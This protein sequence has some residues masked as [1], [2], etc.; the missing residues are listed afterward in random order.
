VATSDELSLQGNLLHVLASR[1]VLT[2][3]TIGGTITGREL[4][5]TVT[6]DG[7]RALVQMVHGDPNSGDS[8]FLVDPTTG[9][10]V[11]V[12]AESHGDFDHLPWPSGFIDHDRTAV[13]VRDAPRGAPD[14]R[15][16]VFADA[17]T[18]VAQG[19]PQP[20]PGSI[21]GDWASQDRLR[22]TP[23]GRTLT[24]VVDGV[25]RIW[26]RTPQGWRGPQRI[27]LPRYRLATLLWFAEGTR[28][29]A[30][31]RYAAF[32]VSYTGRFTT[33]PPRVGYMLDL[34]NGRFVQ[35]GIPVPADI[36]FSPDGK[37]I[38]TAS[39][40]GVVEI[41]P[42]GSGG[43]KP[44]SIP[45][46]GPRTLA[47]S[48]DGHRLAIGY[49]DGSAVVYT[50]D[51]LRRVLS[52]PPSG[53]QLVS[54]ALPNA[55]PR[56]LALDFESRLTTYSLTGASAQRL[57]DWAPGARV[58][59]TV[60]TTSPVVR[61]A[62]GP[63]DVG[64][65]VVAAG[66]LNGR[67]SLYAG[68]ALQHL[69]DL[70]LGP[71]PKDPSVDPA[72]HRKVTALA[73]TPDGE[74]VIAAD[75][76]GH[77]RMWSTE[78]GR[79]L[80]SRDDVPA[81]YLAVSPDG[82]YLATSEFTQDRRAPEDAID[83]D[84]LAVSST[85]RVWDL[86]QPG[87]VVFSD[88][89]DDFTDEFGHTPKPL[90]LSFSPDSSLLAAGTG[91]AYSS[92]DLLLVYDPHTGRRVLTRTAQNSVDASVSA[93]TWTPDSKQLL[94]KSGDGTI[95]A[96]DP[97]TGVG[98]VVIRAGSEPIS[99]IS[100]S[101]DGRLLFTGPSPLTIWDAQTWA[102]IVVKLPFPAEGGDGSMVPTSDGHLF[103]GTAHGIAR[104]DLDPSHWEQA[105][106]DI[107]GRTLTK[108]EWSAYFGDAAY[109]PAC[110]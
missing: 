7:S 42:T 70:S 13:F 108:T 60:P 36:E 45:A 22:I 44:V 82:R 47:F 15:Q 87:T 77:L 37:T 32:V 109:R 92:I 46:E 71:Y 59:D 75:R 43:P 66:L 52:I 57:H 51:P 78:N 105:A 40:D 17:R 97:R 69:R 19:V 29:S 106:C 49:L 6:A 8:L 54:V 80:W 90:A 61:V 102:P 34:R 5:T 68:V 74:A 12:L 84:G 16:L 39:Q 48:A 79:L 35:A 85:V 26:H 4:D 73:V 23:D 72:L 11:K 3:A 83:P 89:L 86:H 2:S 110:T 53:V 96:R 104:L 28:F 101:S 41:N 56:L 27:P 107:A 14:R 62:A 33:G 10:V 88:S 20:V 21:A 63:M 24:S 9:G 64:P 58:I 1:N 31:S 100:Y 30:D 18:G 93:L 50:L 103:I 67:V 25:V 81:A 76:I 94:V 91:S 98:T 99:T 55:E 95:T 65:G 38:A